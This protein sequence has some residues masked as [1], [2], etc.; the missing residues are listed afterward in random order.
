M[1]DISQ[2]AKIGQNVTIGKFVLIEDNVEI[3]ND[4]F[5]G[6]FTLIRKGAKIGKNC[7][8]KSYNEIRTNVII[9]DNSSFGSRCTICADTIIGSNVNIKFGFV[10]TTLDFKKKIDLEA[11][12]V[13]DNAIVGAN[14]T[15]MPGASIGKGS[16]IGACSQLRAQ[17]KE[18]E[19]WYGNPAKFYKMVGEL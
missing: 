4:T 16:M 5:I 8:I 9:G 7:K 6:D 17:T 2:K 14:V 18:N 19:V 11:G 15:L 12:S 3:G 1:Q 13:A 10:T